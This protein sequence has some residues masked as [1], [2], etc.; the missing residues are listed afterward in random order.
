MAPDQA[1]VPR[2]LSVL[3]SSSWGDA[4]LTRMPVHAAD[5]EAIAPDSLV[6]A[7]F[8]M[9]GG[10]AAR[11]SQHLSLRGVFMLDGAKDPY[12]DGDGE[13]VSAAWSEEGGKTDGCR[14]FTAHHVK[15]SRPDMLEA[16]FDRLGVPEEVVDLDSG[17]PP[18]GMHRLVTA[19]DAVEGGTYHSSMARDGEL[20]TSS[21][22]GIAAAEASEAHVFDGYVW[23]MCGLAE[24]DPA[25]SAVSR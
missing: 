22:G 6:V 21:T 18:M 12:V 16:Q 2:L 14:F 23:A 24:V 13:R 25:C 11:L 19:Q 5:V 8:S 1:V 20:P 15:G 7:G 3:K 4:F 17:M 9:G 10:N